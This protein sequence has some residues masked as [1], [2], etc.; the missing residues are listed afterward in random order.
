MRALSILVVEDDVLI[1][2]LLVEVLGV[3]GHV[4]KLESTEES[5][6][7]AAAQFRPD[8]IIVD[9]TLGDGSGIA[10]IDKILEAGPMPHVFVS[11]DPSRVWLVRP[12][13]IVLQK[14]FRQRELADAIWRAIFDS[15][16]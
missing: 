16:S 5:A 3:L 7:T 8:L 12:N 6:V 1:G 9:V 2:N 15:Q 14:P 11:G 10:A 13:A 4:A